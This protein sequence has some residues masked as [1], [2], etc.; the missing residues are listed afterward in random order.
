MSKKTRSRRTRNPGW[1]PKG[2]SGN[3]RGRP[4]GSRAPKPSAFEVLVDK[5]LTVTDHLGTREITI[6]EGLQ[7]RTYQDALAG[8]RMAM[9]EVVKWMI[10]TRGLVREACTQSIS[11]GNHATH[12]AR[13]RQCGCRSLAPRDRDA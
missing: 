2:R 13:S 9:R 10:K 7:Q 11:A 12:L 4:R 3:R 6:E 8:K 5:T 1:F